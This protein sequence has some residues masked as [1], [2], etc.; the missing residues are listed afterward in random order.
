MTEVDIQ[1]PSGVDTV[2]YYERV[3]QTDLGN[4]R[5]YYDPQRADVAHELQM[6]NAAELTEPNDDGLMYVEYQSASIDAVR[7]S[8]DS[9]REGQLIV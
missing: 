6:S 7:A 3:E 4:V 8:D 9:S 2:E 5:V 1:H